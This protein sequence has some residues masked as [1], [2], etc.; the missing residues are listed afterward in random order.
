MSADQQEYEAL[1][2]RASI[3]QKRRRKS[4]Q[5]A[6]EAPDDQA[7]APIPA[8]LD[9]ELNP[10][11]PNTAQQHETYDEEQQQQDHCVQHAEHH[12]PQGQEHHQQNPTGV[13][14][15]YRSA[16]V[17]QHNFEC[18]F[19]GANRGG[20]L[21]EAFEA[22]GLAMFNYMT[23]IDNLTVDPA[24]TRPLLKQAAAAAEAEQQQHL[25]LVPRTNEESLLFNYLDELLFVYSTEYVMM[26]TISI[27][28]L[29]T[30][31]FKVAATGCGEKFDRSKHE[32]G[33]EVKAI[34]YSAMQIR[35]T[36]GDAEVF[37]IV[38]I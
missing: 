17:G 18:E 1:P 6:Q 22:V 15:E 25:K 8:E 3:R 20:S 12:Q 4:E 34:T 2:Q 37:V 28:Q 26:K 10:Q 27:S 21:I 32:C 38:D 7:A 16:A 13:M 14:P 29:D 33:T 36:A 30:E 31:G 5:Q 35:E 23:P 19:C 9:A 24:C 11:Q